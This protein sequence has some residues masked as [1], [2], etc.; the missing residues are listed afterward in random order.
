MTEIRYGGNIFLLPGGREA[1]AVTTNGMTKKDG[2]AVMGAGIAKYARDNFA[3]VDGILG[4]LLKVA[5][6]HARFLGTFDDRNRAAAGLPPAVAVIAFPTKNDWRD[7]SDP[8]L[9]RRSAEEAVRVARENGL[10]KVYMPAPGCSNGRLDYASQV[11]PLLRD[12]LDDT[13]VLCLPPDVYD[14]LS[15]GRESG[16]EIR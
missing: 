4:A 7:P 6:N 12:V 5:G 14:A 1:A 11:R 13:F 9:I 15:H 2:R 10:E 16:K 8:A 3:G